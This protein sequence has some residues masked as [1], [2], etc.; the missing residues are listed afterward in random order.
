MII[1]SGSMSLVKNTKTKNSLRGISGVNSPGKVQKTLDRIKAKSGV[2]EYKRAISFI[3]SSPHHRNNSISREFNSYFPAGLP[4]VVNFSIVEVIERLNA[5]SEKLTDILELQIDLQ[6]KIQ[7]KMYAPALN[8][9]DQLIQHEGVS[10]YLLRALIY[11][12]NSISV[13]SDR[14]VE[15]T[16]LS[17]HLERI[18]KRIK[19]ANFHYLKNIASDLCND[20]N[21]YFNTYRRIIESFDGTPFSHIAKS[22]VSHISLGAEVQNNYLS[23]FYSI[24]LIDAFLYIRNTGRY[25]ENFKKY[26]NEISAQLNN[27]Y[28][29]LCS[30]EMRFEE[31]PNL[32]EDDRQLSLAY[33]RQTFLFIES[34]EAYR[35][36][37]IHAALFNPLENK[38]S[39]ISR[40]EKDL[41]SEYYKPFSLITDLDV[42]S[43][44]GLNV[45]K[46]NPLLS[47][48]L[49]KSTALVKF[50]GSKDGN[51]S[52]EEEVTF[53]KLMS[54]TRDIGIICPTQYFLKLRLNAQSN[55]MRL[56]ISCLISIKDNSHEAEH[57]LRRVLQDMAVEQFDSN[58]KKMLEHLFLISPSVTEHLVLICNETF[59]SKL[60]RITDRPNKAV[61]DRAEMLE[62]FGKVTNNANYIE[63]AK[64]L[65]IDVQIS[66]EKGTI[67]DSRIYV[68]PLKFTQW[69][70]DNILNDL[71]LFL[72]GYCE[73]IPINSITINWKTA[74]F[75]PL[76]KDQIA[77]LLMLCYQEFCTN[78]IF[79][80]AS[81]LGRRIRHGTFKGTGLKEV[82]EFLID[83]RYIEL[84]QDSDFN[85]EY[86]AWIQSYDSML[87]QIRNDNLHINGKRKEKGF[88]YS[89]INT[90]SKK[91]IADH[92]FIDLYN[93]YI[94]NSNTVALPYLI[95]EYCWRIVEEDLTN[96]QK[97]L[98]E[99]K[100]KHAIFKSENQRLKKHQSKLVHGFC[101]E[102][103]SVTADK[104]R[105]ISSWFKKPSS[106]SPSADLI[107][108][109]KVIV[110]ENK[111][112]YED[113]QPEIE[114]P[115]E[116]YNIKGG[117]YHA[118]Y[119]ALS[120][121]VGNA[122]KYGKRNGILIFDIVY[123]PQSHLL[124]SIESEIK[125]TH[126]MGN[127]KR[128]IQSR[129]S[130]E[131]KDAH[132]IE[133]K[134]GIKKLRQLEVDSY[135]YNID[136][137][138]STNRI[139]ATFRVKAGL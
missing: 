19:L 100:S 48:S 54:T 29:R 45:E 135:I 31:E 127:I 131:F 68:D 125:K 2:D 97:R 129:L 139:K 24:S 133:G 94:D 44:Y 102:V 46:F 118:I 128:E 95:T 51:I 71:T 32:N 47:N 122:A 123:T 96:I 61:E 77:T 119:D 87:E 93:N 98:M 115:G 80:V 70:S 12:E 62:W 7:N 109:F 79:G 104:F 136:Y 83:D 75:S 57:E 110:A 28:E 8:T 88:I 43:G 114:A 69:I 138:Y 105:I 111:G 107:L 6:N 26:S 78:A 27:S 113:Y 73:K 103:N 41:I 117:Q 108:L 34:R 14:T 1:Q 90:S 116:E 38:F 130:G 35:Y 58:I 89:T 33:F 92:M 124:L 74:Q 82:K 76:L 22:F 67:D 42:K 91:F 53:I 120:V 112:Y 39:A 15:K 17:E 10:C 84:L 21:D 36:R 99:M 9:I 86:N 66:K 16:P 30:V 121:L 37:T 101:K 4:E 49:E 50:I 65:R 106:A 23:S 59:L 52:K 60:F 25:D 20:N 72:S 18:Y 3:R 63:R 137:N 132:V 11:L 134:S 85:Q 5:N 56:V 126:S 13:I 55:D 40:Y 64:N 81:Y